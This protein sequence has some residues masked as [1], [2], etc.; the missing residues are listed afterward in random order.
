[1]LRAVFV[2]GLE[3]DQVKGGTADLFDLQRLINRARNGLNAEQQQSIARWA[4]KEAALVLRRE[5][6]AY[7]ALREAMARGASVPECIQAIEGAR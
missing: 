7:D 2:Q 4:V 6:R 1:M 5:E 3:Y